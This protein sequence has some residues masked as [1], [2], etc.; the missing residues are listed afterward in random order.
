MNDWTTNNALATPRVA[1]STVSVS[2]EIQPKPSQDTAS[3]GLKD[4]ANSFRLLA[5]ETRLRVLN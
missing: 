4:L 5:D 3:L 1:E 2:E